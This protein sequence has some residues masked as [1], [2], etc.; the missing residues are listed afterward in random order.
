M[1]PNLKA[2]MVRR[3]VKL[4][5]LAK[6]LG[7]TVSTISLKLNGKYPLTWDEAIKI[8]RFIGV[9]IP[10]EVLFSEEAC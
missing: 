8:K 2:E 5:D 6:E 3:D 9:D 4:A 1:Y 10:I 7:I